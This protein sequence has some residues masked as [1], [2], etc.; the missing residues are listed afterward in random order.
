[1]TYMSDAC[2]GAREKLMMERLRHASRFFMS[3]NY[4]ARFLLILT[5][6][7]VLLNIA[8]LSVYHWIHIPNLIFNLQ[9]R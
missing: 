3:K 2:I 9:Q 4:R 7:R 8:T 5:H 6:R 1:M